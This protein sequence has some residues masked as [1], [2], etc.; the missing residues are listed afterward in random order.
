MYISVAAALKKI[1]FFL[2][3]YGMYK[4]L[5]QPLRLVTVTKLPRPLYKMFTF[6]V[7]GEP[8]YALGDFRSF[9]CPGVPGYGHSR[10]L[11]VVPVCV[12]CLIGKQNKPT[13]FQVCVLSV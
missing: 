5:P 12:Q 3:I 4:R 2:G 8:A 10:A 13:L 1:E 7:K 9:V 11:C 6:V